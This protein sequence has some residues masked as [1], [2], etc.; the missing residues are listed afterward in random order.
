MAGAMLPLYILFKTSGAST[1]HRRR[2]ATLEEGYLLPISFESCSPFTSVPPHPNSTILLSSSISD[3]WTTRWCRQQAFFSPY[4][5]R[6]PQ[7]EFRHLNAWRHF[8]FKRT[9]ATNNVNS[10]RNLCFNQMLVDVTCRLN[11]SLLRI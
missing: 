1:V 7:Y 6:T 11:S 2:Q 8:L 10:Y 3:V 9:N 5:P 4:P